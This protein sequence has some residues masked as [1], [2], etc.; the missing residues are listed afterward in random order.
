MSAA[1]TEAQNQVG[2]KAEGC[3]CVDVPLG[4]YANQVS[5]YPPPEFGLTRVPVGLDRCIALEVLDLW[6]RGIVTTA[7]CCGHNISPAIISVREEHI[8]EMQ[9]LGYEGAPEIPGASHF[10]ARS[11]SSSEAEWLDP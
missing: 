4:S 6:Q 1:V 2:R 11:R 7:S 5:V 8:A 3:V 9:A 10:R